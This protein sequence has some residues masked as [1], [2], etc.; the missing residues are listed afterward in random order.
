MRPG[1]LPGG[2]RLHHWRRVVQRRDEHVAALVAEYE[3]R[4]LNFSISVTQEQWIDTID[5]AHAADRQRGAPPRAGFLVGQQGHEI[6]R[7]RRQQR[8]GHRTWGGIRHGCGRWRHDITQHPLI[9]EPEYSRHLLFERHFGRARRRRRRR[10]NPSRGGRARARH[11]AKGQSERDRGT[12][13][14]G[15][16]KAARCEPIEV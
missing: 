3:C 2:A 12:Y 9:L 5:Q 10:R 8:R 11:G 4:R 14:R 6:G 15:L 7:R 16:T 1:A 13:H